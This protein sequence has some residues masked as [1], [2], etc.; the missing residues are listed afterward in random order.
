MVHRVAAV[1]ADGTLRTMG[2]ANE[3]V[4][5]TPVA[6][7]AVQGVGQVVVPFAGLPKLWSRQEPAMLSAWV[8]SVVLACRLVTRRRRAAPIVIDGGVQA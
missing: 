7:G 2:D 6:P 3:T 8:L 4:D 5:S 1:R